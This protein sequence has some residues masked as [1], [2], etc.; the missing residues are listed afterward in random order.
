[1]SFEIK[2]ANK[3][4]TEKFFLKYLLYL[5]SSNEKS[6]VTSFAKECLFLMVFLPI[7]ILT[8]SND[9]LDRDEIHP[10]CKKKVKSC[11]L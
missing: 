5:D 7:R 6:N 8:I 10:L 3:I 9:T 4:R 2:Q 11:L 1:M